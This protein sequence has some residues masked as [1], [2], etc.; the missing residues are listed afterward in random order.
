[1]FEVHLSVGLLFYFIVAY[2]F[3]RKVIEPLLVKLYD[4]MLSM[5]S[6]KKTGA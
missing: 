2:V 6:K 4:K 3:V 5:L 1:M